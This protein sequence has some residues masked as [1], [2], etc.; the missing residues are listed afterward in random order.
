LLP[1]YYSLL[2][3]SGFATKSVLFSFSSFSGKKEK[4]QAWGVAP[5]QQLT[6]QTAVD[7]RALLEALGS[8]GE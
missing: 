5:Q 8:A 2:S 3:F 4:M 7:F 6:Q 1:R